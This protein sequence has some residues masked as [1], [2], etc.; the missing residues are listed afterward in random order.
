MHA[1]RD[2]SVTTEDVEQAE[3]I[4]G[5]DV[6][7]LKGKTTHQKPVPV[8]NDSADIE[9]VK[10]CIDTL[11]VNKIPFLT[12]VCRN[13]QFRT[14]D[15]LPTTTL[16]SYRSGIETI[17]WMYKTVGFKVTSLTLQTAIST[18]S[19]HRKAAALDVVL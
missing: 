7:S 6:G 17:V 19:M 9:A 10:L 12:S 18:F 3:R 13:I 4:F 16:A 15:I 1:I 2:N 5:P 14:A 11:F 8:V